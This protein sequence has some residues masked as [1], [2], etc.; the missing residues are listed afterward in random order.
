LK[1]DEI[2]KQTGVKV[3]KEDFEKL[4]QLAG[5]GWMPGD[6]VIVFSVGEGIRKD[7]ATVDAKK[8]YVIN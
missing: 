8:K 1:G 6:Q 4:M 7:Q 2:M 3:T 5:K